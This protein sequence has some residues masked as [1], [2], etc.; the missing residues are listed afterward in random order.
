M[1]ERETLPEEQLAIL[2]TSETP[3]FRLLC[4]LLQAEIDNTVGLLSSF[5]LAPPQEQKYLGYLRAYRRIL[6]LFKQVPKGIQAA[7]RKEIDP[8]STD[9]F[10]TPGASDEL[11]ISNFEEEPDPLAPFMARGDIVVE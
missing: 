4:D 2:K 8:T 9:I 10:F 3:G 7:M 5:D 1:Q 6:F 11:A